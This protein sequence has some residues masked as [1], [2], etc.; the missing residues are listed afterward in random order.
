[1]PMHT[2]GNR[3]IQDKHGVNIDAWTTKLIKQA[4]ESYIYGKQVLW[5]IC[6]MNPT[7]TQAMTDHT[8]SW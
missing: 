7:L 6:W 1:M 4:S 8:M 2:N 3:F 5:W